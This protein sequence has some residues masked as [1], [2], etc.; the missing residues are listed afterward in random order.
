[1]L[2]SSIEQTESIR[3]ISD[4]DSDRIVIEDLEKG[5][6]ERER[7]TSEFDRRT[8]GTYSLG[9]LFVVY[10]ISKHVCYCPNQK[11]SSVSLRFYIRFRRRIGDLSGTVYDV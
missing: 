5:E 4:H 3:V 8:V 7:A 9:N 2:T 11:G 1:M 6:N 10:D